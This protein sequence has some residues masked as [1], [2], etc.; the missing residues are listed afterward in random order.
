MT[1]KQQLESVYDWEKDVLSG[2]IVIVAVV[3]DNNIQYAEAI[4]SDDMFARN[5]VPLMQ[6]NPQDLEA[7]GNELPD[8]VL[9]FQAW[10]KEKWELAKTKNAFNSMIEREG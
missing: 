6:V 8:G 10:P 4:V 1:F 3:T 7:C 5:R 9:A 2:D